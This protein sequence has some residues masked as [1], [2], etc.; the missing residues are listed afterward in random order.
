MRTCTTQRSGRWPAR[1]RAADGR[2]R[3]RAGW[4]PPPRRRRR[5]RPR[6]P[7]RPRRRRRGGGPG[8]RGAQ[9]ARRRRP[10]PPRN[11]SRAAR[12]RGSGT[13]V[14]PEAVIGLWRGCGRGGRGVQSRPNPRGS[15]TSRASRSMSRRSPQAA[16][17]C[18]S[19]PGSRAD[20]RAT[21]GTRPAERGAPRGI[22]I[23]GCEGRG[24]GLAD[25]GGRGADGRAD[26]PGDALGERPATPP[27]WLTSPSPDHYSPAA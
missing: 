11:P 17:R 14:Q 26:G 16:R 13:H 6:R 22:P 20:D 8:G 18:G 9:R 4:R 3:F 19:R 2:G 1:G 21:P 25:L 12:G 10:P 15:S 24:Q 23:R 5:A 27:R 7:R